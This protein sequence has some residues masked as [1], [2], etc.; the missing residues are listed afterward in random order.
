MGEG[1]HFGQNHHIQ[2]ILR[3]T[4]ALYR[5]SLML[6]ATP[7]STLLSTVNRGSFERILHTSLCFLG[8]GTSTLYKIAPLKR[9]EKHCSTSKKIMLEGRGSSTLFSIVNWVCCLREYSLPLSVFMSELHHLCSKWPHTTEWM[10]QWSLMFEARTSSTLFS[11]VYWV[12]C[13]KESSLPLIVFMGRASAF[14]KI[15][16]FKW[17]EEAL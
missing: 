5:E 7:Y 16:P 14:C 2:G 6:E 12:S 17:M 10:M 13:W 15:P 9:M 3:T 4:L 1:I 8:W 11:I